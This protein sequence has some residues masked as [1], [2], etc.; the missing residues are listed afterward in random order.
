LY[1]SQGNIKF[2]HAN[3]TRLSFFIFF[4]NLIMYRQVAIPLAVGRL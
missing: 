2:V 3:H 4:T 1:V